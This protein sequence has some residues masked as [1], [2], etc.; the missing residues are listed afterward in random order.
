MTLMEW[1]AIGELVGG[2]A[3]IGSLIYVGLQVKQGTQ[4]SRAATSQAFSAQYSDVLL[5]LTAPDF[6]DV[7]LRGLRD[8]KNLKGS[9]VVSFNSW[10]HAVMRILESFY[11]QKKDGTFVAEIFDSWVIQID[12]LFGE[13]GVREFWALR[14]HQYSAEFVSY[15]DEQLA[16]VTPTQLYPAE[17]F[18]TSPGVNDSA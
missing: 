18:G 2:V 7:F 13:Q 1:G 14:K 5:R 4:A 16:T 9:D 8:L 17:L 11:Y 6:R 15:F 3:I 12:D 10:M